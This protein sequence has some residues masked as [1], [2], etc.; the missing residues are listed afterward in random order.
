MSKPLFLL[1]AGRL[2]F[3]CSVPV[4]D[5]EGGFPLSASLLTSPLP[6]VLFACF[7]SSEF[8]GLLFLFRVLG[9]GA[10]CLPHPLT[11]MVR[12]VCA[13]SRSVVSA[14][15]RPPGLSPARFLCPWGFSREEYWGGLLF[16]TPGG[17]P[18]P[19]IKPPSLASPALAGGFLPLAPPGKQ[20]VLNKKSHSHEDLRPAYL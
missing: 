14:S 3:P 4:V 10:H 1:A 8:Q 19:G 12:S 2:H 5:L 17:L 20:Q 18:D 9:S 6:S 7:P 13:L 15:L 11:S 16:P